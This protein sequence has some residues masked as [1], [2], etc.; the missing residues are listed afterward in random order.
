MSDS[1][2][3]QSTKQQANMVPDKVVDLMVGNILRKNG[4]KTE[5]VKKNLSD[6]QKQMLRELVEDLKEQVDQFSKGKQKSTE[7]SE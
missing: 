3:Q 1:P 5:D 2:K 4:V 7:S 6:E